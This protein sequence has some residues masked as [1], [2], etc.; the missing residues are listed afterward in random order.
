MTPGPLLAFEVTDG[1]RLPE[2]LSPPLTIAFFSP[3]LTLETYCANANGSP[4]DVTYDRAHYPMQADVLE[5]MQFLTSISAETTARKNLEK[6]L[7]AVLNP[8]FKNSQ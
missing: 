2:S 5:R 1:L 8:R 4:C 6:F 7:R 3:Y